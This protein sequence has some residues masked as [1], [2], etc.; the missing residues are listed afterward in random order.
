MNPKDFPWVGSGYIEDLLGMPKISAKALW[1]KA[2]LEDIDTWADTVEPVNHSC[3]C[4]YPN[5]AP[6]CW[7]CT[8]CEECAECEYCTESHGGP[9]ECPA[10]TDPIGYSMKKKD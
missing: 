10:L 1:V 5:A 4:G 3:G 8:D 9:E 2:L 6:P 7:H